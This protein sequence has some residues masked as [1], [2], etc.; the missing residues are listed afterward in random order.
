MQ[1]GGDLLEIYSNKI[2]IGKRLDKNILMAYRG[3]CRT[4]EWINF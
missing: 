4:T 3:G 1:W 2:F